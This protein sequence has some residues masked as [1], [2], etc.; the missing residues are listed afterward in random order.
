MN[1]KRLEVAAPSY[2]KA[3]EQVKWVNRLDIINLTYFWQ[4][5]GK[6]TDD[7][8]DSLIIDEL[9]QRRRSS[10]YIILEPPIANKRKRPYNVQNVKSAI[11]NHDEAVV[12]ERR[13]GKISYTSLPSNQKYYR[14]IEVYGL[15]S[16][17]LILTSE[18][19]ESKFSVMAKIMEMYRAD[20][21]RENVKGVY[22]KVRLHGE[23]R[24]FIMQYTPSTTT[25]DG[26]YLFFKIEI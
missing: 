2:I 19:N 15:E 23:D 11:K 5:H 25:R 13:E 18:H 26:L 20:A 7:R 10:C 8:L 24:A 22:K 16:G 3:L 21:L 4:R 9:Q 1:F 12:R 17:K 6:I 14:V